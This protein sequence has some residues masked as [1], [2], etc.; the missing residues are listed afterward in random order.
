MTRYGP[1]T[2]LRMREQP[3]QQLGEESL[4]QVAAQGEAAMKRHVM[5]LRA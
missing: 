4:A 1:R 2:N 3:L 5:V